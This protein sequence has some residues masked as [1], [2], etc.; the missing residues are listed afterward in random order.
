MA[1][2]LQF[3]FG[4]FPPLFPVVRNHVRHEHMLDLF[5]R[6]PAAKALQHQLDEV[7]V[8]EG[9]HLAQ[10]LNIRRLAGQDVVAGNRFEGFGGKAQVHRMARL[11]REIDGQ[12]RKDRIDGFD[13]AEPPASVHAIAALHQLQQRLHVLAPDLAGGHQFLELFFHNTSKN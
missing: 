11:V 10:R 3:V 5:Q 12:P 1:V 4:H 7:E 8:M 6:R 9:G 13:F 2:L